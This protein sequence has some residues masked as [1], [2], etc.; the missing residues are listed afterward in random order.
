MTRDNLHFRFTIVGEQHSF[1]L[2]E[3]EGEEALSSAYRFEVTLLSVE[4]LEQPESLVWK[5]CALEMK[6]VRQR[7]VKGIVSQ[8][9]L[10]DK[11]GSDYQYKISMRPAFWG[12]SQEIG[13]EVFLECSVIDC[14]STVLS[15]TRP[16]LYLPFELKLTQQYSRQEIFCKYNESSFDF[17]SRL[18]EQFGLYYY[19]DGSAGV[20]TLIICDDKI[21]HQPLPNPSYRYYPPTGLDV[22]EQ[23]DLVSS[24]CH[25]S[26]LLPNNILLK[27]YDY[28]KPDVELEGIANVDE[29]GIGQQFFYGDY[30]DGRQQ[31]N[32]LAKHRAEQSVSAARCCHAQARDPSMC[33]GSTFTL[34]DHFLASCNQAYLIVGVSHYGRFG[35]ADNMLLYRNDLQC[36]PANQQYRAPN[37][38]PRPQIAGLINATIDGAGEGEVAM[39][40]EQGRYKVRLPFDLGN[41]NEGKA[42][43]W[44][45]KLTP[46]GGKNEGMHFPLRKGAEVKL[47]CEQGDPSRLVI[48]GVVS[49]SNTPSVVNQGNANAHVI[50]TA[51]GTS[52]TLQDGTAQSHVLIQS[53]AGTYIKI[54]S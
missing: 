23:V 9:M 28:E 38:T 41:P 26:E 29:N 42:S 16:G 39:L 45:R 33:S 25:S 13:C 32:A 30:F 49:N 24:F 11:Q 40:D 14:I 6:G 7:A 10:M 51:S 54:S 4:L 20:E 3:F 47:A 53:D 22:Y 18:M 12:L 15:K 31:G 8:V 19:F 44:V 48:V 34:T 52:M 37:H 5:P 36:L 43:H 21:A 27:H 2:I 1:R 50:K 35:G 17:V 46:F